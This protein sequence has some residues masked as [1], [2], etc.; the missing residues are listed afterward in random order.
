MGGKNS[1]GKSAGGQF[2]I[3][4]IQGGSGPGG[5][6]AAKFGVSVRVCAAL[7]SGGAEVSVAELKRARAAGSGSATG[8]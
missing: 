7:Y 4:S 8:L 1:A 2:A 6:V 5:V 3:E